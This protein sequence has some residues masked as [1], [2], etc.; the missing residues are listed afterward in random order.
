MLLRD[1]ERSAQL[2]ALS[3]RFGCPWLEYDENIAAPMLLLLRLDLEALKREL[4]FPRRVENGRATVVACAPGPALAQHVQAVLGVSEVQ[5]LVTLPSDLVRI[6]EHNQ[7]LNPGFPPIAGRTP[8]ARV[9]T[10]LAGR[11][12]LLAHYRTLL[13]KSRTGLAFIRTGISF[14]TIALLFMRIFDADY[15]LLLELPLLV[16][17]CVMS[18]DGFKWYL[19][20]RKI[21]D[22]SA[23]SWHGTKPTGGSTV[24]AVSNEAVAP[25]YRRSLEVEGALALRQEWMSMSPVMRRRYLANDRTDLAEERTQLACYRTLMAKTRTGLAFVRTG[26][27]FVGLGFALVRHFHAS[28]WL[29][30]DITLILIGAWMAGEGFLSYASGRRA[31]EDGYAT[32]RAQHASIWDFSFPHSHTVA[33]PMRHSVPLPVRGGHAPGIW[34]TTGL[35]LERT[36]LAERRNVMA[37][38]RTVMAR[39]RTG[40]AFM[41][42]GFSILMVGVV[43]VFSFHGGGVG[44]A[45]FEAAM[46]VGGLA[47]IGDGLYLNLPAERYRRQF[48]YCGGDMEI[49]VPDYGIP[50]RSW[51]TVVFNNDPS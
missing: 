19:V 31:G 39:A 51:R 15:L 46:V 13:A 40:Y 21:Q 37:R 2:A 7:D 26:F 34:A 5:F 35:A 41:R 29:V 50:V 28:G 22:R 23:V 9:R 44:W 42:T 12:S 3:E 8:L 36:V 1:L 33:S 4:W 24:L 16:V 11:R 20:S 6:V 38:L 27:A 17:G 10:Y 30:L 14:V 32:A 49:G 48:P 25:V 45:L 18:Y 47:L 43:F